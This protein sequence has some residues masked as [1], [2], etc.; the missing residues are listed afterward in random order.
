MPPASSDPDGGNLSFAWE[1]SPTSGVTIS[2]PSPAVTAATF[3]RP[4]IYSF[5]ATG[6]DP[7]NGS[8]PITREI[9]AYHANDFSSFGKGAL[10]PFW[11]VSGAE[12]RDSYSAD[13]WYSL[14][15][16][17][18]HLV[19]QILDNS[20][21][22]LAFNNPSH[23]LFLRPLPGPADFALQTDLT[24]ETRRSGSFTTGLY[25]VLTES[26]APVRYA[27]GVD[28]GNNLAVK[29]STGAAFIDLAT[30][31]FSDVSAKLRVLREG[32]DLRFQQRVGGVWTTLHTRTIPA[33]STASEGGLFL[34]TTSAQSARVAFDY[35]L[36]ADTTHVAGL[37]TQVRITEL[38]YHPADPD[39]VEFI[40]L[41][42]TGTTTV[43]LQGM[44]FDD[45]QPFSAFTFGDTPLAPGAYAVIA[46]DA[47]DFQK[48]YGFDPT[49]EW[50]TGAL[51]NG[52]ERVTLRDETGAVIHDFTYDSAAP[53]PT[54]PDGQGPSL[55]IIDPFGDYDDATN[56]RASFEI[57]GTPGGLGAG[58][59]SDGDGQPDGW[60]IL[61]GTDPHDPSSRFQAT[62]G[63]NGSGQPTLSFPSALGVDYR[64]DYTDSLA[65]MNWQQLMVI[66]GT[67]NPI[68]ITDPTTPMPGQRFYQVTPQP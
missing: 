58:A 23:P 57:G 40:E 44:S 56:W 22:P 43:N 59:D 53:W 10:E 15:E 42:N 30:T 13:A 25:V 3:S 35:L 38:M 16:T 12:L 2:N 6:T 49:A 46:N 50:T 5:T 48:R 39:T 68:T 26:G 66:P 37:T 52:G 63:V 47:N 14:E 1:H 33:D 65:P 17:S 11:T 21:K 55:E 24:L 18:G 29:R 36:L 54:T 67:G 28:A 32:T 34:A 4:G 61:L 51:T 31:S 19:V 60:E 8:A 7:S 41:Q 9:T 20:A 62:T 64:I 45:G 27:F